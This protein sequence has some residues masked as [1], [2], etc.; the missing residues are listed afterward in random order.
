M[1]PSTEGINQVIR[2]NKDKIE[3]GKISDGFHTFDELYDHR[4]VLYIALCKALKDQ[5]IIFR[6]QIHSDGSKWEGWFLLGLNVGKG[7]QISYHLPMSYWEECDFA[8][9]P[10]AEGL[11][12]PKFD[13]HT[14]ED[15]LER[16]KN[17]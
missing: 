5:H 6:T 14:S 12:V 2:N 8:R 17:L 4:I 10:I 15:V 13:G 11:P 7:R 3:V 9:N 1:I 16:L